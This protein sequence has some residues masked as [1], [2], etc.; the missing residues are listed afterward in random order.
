MST[1]WKTSP[2]RG[3]SPPVPKAAPVVLKALGK[4]VFKALAK[5]LV[6][7]VA[8]LW[9]LVTALL[10]AAVFMLSALWSLWRLLR[11]GRARAPAAVPVAG[12]S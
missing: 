2:G 10:S 4:G 12:T 8:A 9:T 6:L 1:R 5:V 7:T 3:A 11:R